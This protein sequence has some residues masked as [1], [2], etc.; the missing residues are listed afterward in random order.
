QF[1]N[2]GIAFQDIADLVEICRK[3]RGRTIC[4]EL[5][6]CPLRH[7]HKA[8]QIFGC[9]GMKRTELPVP[10]RISKETPN[11]LIWYC[12][13]EIGGEA[14]GEAWNAARGA[15]LSHLCRRIVARARGSIAERRFGRV[16][17]V[18]RAKVLVTER[19]SAAM[20]KGRRRRRQGRS[21]SRRRSG[22][23]HFQDFRSDKAHARH[24]RF[25][26]RGGG[27]MNS[28]IPAI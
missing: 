10:L 15:D 28:A 12:E 9:F 1:Q 3:S 17:T 20:I 7:E 14:H 26:I 2:S 19:D 21:A 23:R 18:T 11:L 5:I 25:E 24:R 22:A 13:P 4:S 16:A 27:P 8:F 6:R